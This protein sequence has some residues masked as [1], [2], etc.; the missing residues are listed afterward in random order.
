MDHSEPQPGDRYI[1]TRLAGTGHFALV[2]LAWDQQASRQVALKMTREAQASAAAPHPFAQEAGRLFLLRHPHIVALL[3]YTILEHRPTLV[4]EYVPFTLQQRYQPQGTRQRSLP[5]AD[6]H[7]YL[8]QAASALEYAHSNGVLHCDIKPQNMLLDAHDQ[9]KISDFGIAMALPVFSRPQSMGGTRGYRAPEGVASPQADQYSLA[10][11]V[12]E[13]LTGHRPGLWKGLRPIQAVLFPASPRAALLSIMTRALARRPAQRFRSVQEFADAC[14]QAYTL[15]RAH[16]ART[17]PLVVL[18]ALGLLALLSL[19]WPLLGSAGWQA[20]PTPG[21]PRAVSTPDIT[22][23]ARFAGKTYQQAL[24]RTPTLSS[25]L[26]GQD[27]NNWQVATGATGSCGFVHATYQVASLRSGTRTACLEQARDFSD[28]ACQVD[29]QIASTP[30]DY[31]GLSVRASSRSGYVFL[32]GTD[33]WYKFGVI[34]RTQALVAGFSTAI[35]T[36]PTQWNRL[37]IIA[38]GQTFYLYINQRFITAITD[39]SL[40]RGLV[41]LNTED[42]TSPTQVLFRAMQVWFLA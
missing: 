18:F 30:G 33:Q 27:G 34:G 42:D 29:L 19:A 39:S 4:M 7:R 38:R 40:T 2:Y 22:A 36:S 16:P 24:S 25:S 11:T 14:E 21:L 5:A 3:D 26:A 9:I 10:V 37:T 15:A 13:G 31:G 8:Q 20:Q 28:L 23:T 41:G 6:I 12:Y 17:R 1:L 35:L 32:I